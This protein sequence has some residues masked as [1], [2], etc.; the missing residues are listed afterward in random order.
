MATE[1]RLKS[2]VAAGSDSCLHGQRIGGNILRRSCHQISISLYRKEGMVEIT[3]V[4]DSHPRLYARTRLPHRRNQVACYD[5]NFCP[6]E[7]R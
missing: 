6:R 1:A 5:G 3:V 4:L 2:V 7:W